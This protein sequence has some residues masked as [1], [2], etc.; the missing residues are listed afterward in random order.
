M[1]RICACAVTSCALFFSSCTCYLGSSALTHFWSL[2][3]AMQLCIM[4]SSSITIKQTLKKKE[5]RKLMFHLFCYQCLHVL[6]LNVAIDDANVA[7]KFLNKD[8]GV[9]R[10]LAALR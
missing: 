4:K 3:W 8:V 6:P 1:T 7:L 2:K 9:F 5:K 10:R